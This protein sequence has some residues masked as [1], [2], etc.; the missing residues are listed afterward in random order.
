MARLTEGG[1]HQKRG[2]RTWY[3]RT[4]LVGVAMGRTMCARCQDSRPGKDLEE[5]QDG[6]CGTSSTA[7]ATARPQ[8]GWVGGTGGQGQGPGKAGH[9]KG[10]REGWPCV[11]CVMGGRGHKQGLSLGFGVV[12]GGREVASG[13]TSLSDEGLWAWRCLCVVSCVGGNACDP[14]RAPRLPPNQCGV[15]GK[16]YRSREQAEIWPGAC[17]CIVFSINRHHS[18]GSRPAAHNSPPPL[19]FFSCVDDHGFG[20]TQRGVQGFKGRGGRPAGGVFMRV[21]GVALRGSGGP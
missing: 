4:V 21:P 7:E 14:A 8:H 1:R 13:T 16:P 12:A 9:R 15:E 3:G 17:E 11:F 10:R 2:G 20:W 6:G 5:E 18:M 19:S